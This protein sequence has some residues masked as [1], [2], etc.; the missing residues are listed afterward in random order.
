MSWSVKGSFTEHEGKCAP[1]TC[2]KPMRKIH[3]RMTKP[4]MT[5][6]IT[7]WMNRYCCL[8]I[9]T[10][11]WY[12]YCSSH[13]FVLLSFLYSDDMAHSLFSFIFVYPY[14]SYFFFIFVCFHSHFTSVSFLLHLTPLIVK[15]LSSLP[16]CLLTLFPH[17]I[18]TA[19][20]LSIF[21]YLTSHCLS[22]AL[23]LSS[24][25]PSPHRLTSAWSASIP[26]WHPSKGGLSAALPRPPSP[27]SRSSLPSKCWRGPKNT[28]R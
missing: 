25:S 9:A 3:S 21:L 11:C 16:P 20:N 19:S 24:F 23:F 1:R 15:M 6:T 28:E 17:L 2:P 18:E 4:L 14:Q 5:Q 12:F 10:P 27:I 7:D 8:L 22:H 13:T 26:H